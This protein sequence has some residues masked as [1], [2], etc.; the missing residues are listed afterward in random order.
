MKLLKNELMSLC[1]TEDIFQQVY[2]TLKESY[3]FHWF[4]LDINK[5]FYGRVEP[6]VSKQLDKIS[7]FK[8]FILYMKRLGPQKGKLIA[9]GCKTSHI[10]SRLLL[11]RKCHW[12]IKHCLQAKENG[13]FLIHN[14]T[15]TLKVLFL[16]CI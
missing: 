5:A 8:H 15:K 10:F 2:F 1:S 13:K 11:V 7:W 9:L 6:Y 14:L 4:P 3:S 16:C 12:Q